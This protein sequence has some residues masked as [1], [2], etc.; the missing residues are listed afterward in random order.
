[1]A[2]RRRNLGENMNEQKQ[3]TVAWRHDV[4]RHHDCPILRRNEKQLNFYFN[5][6]FKYVLPIL[7]LFIIFTELFPASNETNAGNYGNVVT[8]E[9]KVYVCLSHSFTIF[10]R[11]QRYVDIVIKFRFY[12][13][14]WCHFTS[15]LVRHRYV[16]FVTSWLH[17]NAVVN[18][19]IPFKLFLIYYIILEVH[20]S[21]LFLA[22]PYII[23]HTYY[24]L[25]CRYDVIGTRHNDV[26]HVISMIQQIF[27][28]A[29][30]SQ[31]SL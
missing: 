20:F 26:T 12:Y 16:T 9:T 11:I 7:Y 27:L 19:V 8:M 13:S 3:W 23:L 14:L 1:M 30:P 28:F 6:N 17:H 29:P 22:L 10:H 24:S 5:V 31:H 2:P 25:P 21:R 18:C 15:L 4:W